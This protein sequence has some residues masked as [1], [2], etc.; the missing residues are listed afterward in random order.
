MDKL[1]YV[2]LENNDGTYSSSIPLA[3]DS[4]HVDVNGK[5][6]TEELT[7]K[8]SNSEFDIN[9]TN[10][11]NEVRSLAD[12]SPK[13]TYATVSALVSANPNTGVYVI[14]ADGHI[15]S[16]IKGASSAIDLGTYQATE[17]ASN[18]VKTDNLDIQMINKYTNLMWT[19]DHSNMTTPITE[20]YNNTSNHMEYIQNST[21]FAV[22]IPTGYYFV[23]SKIRVTS[24]TS[25]GKIRF[26][27]GVRLN[28]TQSMINTSYPYQDASFLD[29]ELNVDKICYGFINNTSERPCRFLLLL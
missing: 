5:T 24:K 20:T 22:T 21:S 26:R 19:S 17:I 9:M 8:V 4:Q 2:K 16:W 13:G 10:I 15:Y 7:N 29:N 1:K 3:V 28:T 6:L 11:Q 23:A 25:G 18:G 12:G 27:Q 14:Q